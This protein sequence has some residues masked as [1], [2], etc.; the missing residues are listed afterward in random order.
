MAILGCLDRP[1]SGHYSLKGVD[2]ARLSEPDLARIRSD[3]I[4]FV[5]QTFNLLA[6][7]SALENVALPLFYAAGGPARRATRFARA[8]DALLLLG[9]GDRDRNT[10]AQ[11][12]GGQ[13]Q[14]VA[15]A[16]ALINQPAVLLA[17][18][19]TGNVDTRTSHD[20]MQR[21]V[22]L[23]REQNVT[24]VVVTHESDIAAYADRVITIRDGEIV[25]DE[26]KALREPV[27]APAESVP[28]S[29]L[30]RRSRG[31]TVL[32]VRVH[33]PGSGHAIA[34]AQRPAFG[35]DDARRV[36]RSGGAD[37]DGG[38]RSGRQ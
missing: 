5:F 34:S 25:C 13:Q 14:R 33:D 15:I 26:R 12:S 20:I 7:T 38:R 19:P 23:N 22:M 30:R 36:H 2:V 6:R 28:A 4:G 3:R 37:R 35:T 18:E 31:G 32:G 27:A 9:L 29:S 16:R 1:T 8:R 10:P 21:L 24:I 17:D 11:L